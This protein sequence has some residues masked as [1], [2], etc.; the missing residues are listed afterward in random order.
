M[1]YDGTIETMN[2]KT[3]EFQVIYDDEVCNYA[4]LDDIRNSDMS[5]IN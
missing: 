4:L 1:W 2:P 5:I 3:N